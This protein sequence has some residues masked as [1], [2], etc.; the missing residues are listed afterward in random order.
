MSATKSEM[1]ARPSSEHDQ[2]VSG[3]ATGAGQGHHEPIEEHKVE[4]LIVHADVFA[5]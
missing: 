2:P 1:T 3:R 5:Q 4:D